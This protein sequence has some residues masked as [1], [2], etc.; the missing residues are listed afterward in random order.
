MQMSLGSVQGLIE[1]L[2]SLRGDALDEQVTELVA[3][4]REEN[5]RPGE[6]APLIF[7]AS[8]DALSSLPDD[9]ATPERVLGLI[10]VAVHYQDNARPEASLAPAEAALACA[11]RTGDLTWIG[12]ASKIV[13]VGR[14]YLGDFPGAVQAFTEALD[15]AQAT[16]DKAQETGNW[17]NLGLAY[18]SA[19][20]F[21]DA[22][23]MFEKTVQLA[24]G[25]P[26]AERPMQR[27]LANVALAALQAGDIAKGLKA[28]QR[29]SSCLPDPA[30]AADFLHRVNVESHHVRLLLE[31]NFFEEAKQHAAHMRTYAQ[32]SRLE[33]AHVNSAYAEGLVEV[34]AGN[35]DIGFSRIK[36]TVEFARKNLPYSVRDGLYTL[37]KA[38]DM[39]GQPGAALVYMRELLRL[40]EDAAELVVAHHRRQLRQSDRAIDR[41]AAAALLARQEDLREQLSDHDLIRANVALLEQ[42]SVAAELHDDSTGEHCYRVGRLSSILAADFGVD[43]HTCF[44]IDLAARMHDIGKLSVPDA[45]LLKPG[46]LTPEERAIMETHTTSGAKILA[47]SNVPQMYVAEE[48]ARHHHERWDGTGYPT[49]LKGP[50]IPLA[51]RITALADVYDALTHVRPY[52]HA[53]TSAEALHEIAS[54]RGKH[55]DPQLTD[56]FLVLVPRLQR[57][58]GDLDAF[59]AVE[60]KNNPFVANRARLA[61]ALKGEDGAGVH[62]E[63]PRR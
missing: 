59:L 45:I 54:L 35:R 10:L 51:A 16:G 12:K 11:R 21:S 44:L 18:L 14:S 1:S 46:K 34:A 8:F 43:E 55:F 22:A 48:I 36:R 24:A 27:A 38:Y 25:Q 9:L 30:T 56:L 15:C 42:Q 2:P 47:K 19:G 53:W 4:L 40:N 7:S 37:I 17:N 31:L 28:V 6:A 26:G 57:Q 29:A 50:N 5:A 49:R 58:H 33:L 62:V 32:S 41:S 63:D 39:A 23:A 3:R 61:R 60:A 52:K 20:Q 13:G